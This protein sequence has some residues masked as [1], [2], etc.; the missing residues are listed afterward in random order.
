MQELDIDHY[1]IAFGHPKPKYGFEEYSKKEH[2]RL[3]KPEPGMLLDLM[4]K[5]EAEPYQTMMVGDREEDSE[6]ARNAGCLFM[7]TADFFG[8]DE[9]KLWHVYGLYLGAC[10]R[11]KQGDMP[12]PALI[13]NPDGSGAIKWEHAEWVEWSSLDLAPQI[14]GGALRDEQEE[15][16]KQAEAKAKA[17]SPADDF[18]PFLDAV[19]LP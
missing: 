17:Q 16:K 13:L 10:K 12:S 18:D 3:R 9:Q 19:E 15:R 1:E 14:I 6:A 2:L 11:L 4:K 7:W 5:C 8:S